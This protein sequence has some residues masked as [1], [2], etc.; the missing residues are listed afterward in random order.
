[1]CIWSRHSKDTMYS[2]RLQ[3]LLRTFQS[4]ILRVGQRPT[5]ML[6]HPTCTP[7]LSTSYPASSE[8][9]L[10]KLYLKSCTSEAVLQRDN[11]CIEACTSS[12]CTKPR[13]PTKT[14][15]KAPFNQPGMT[16]NCALPLQQNWN[17]TTN[18]NLQMPC[19]AH[20]QCCACCASMLPPPS[21]LP[22]TALL[23]LQ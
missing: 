21:S 13:H 3:A 9:V 11:V 1:M 23:L 10:W 15:A 12:K 14:R 8:A 19:G 16:C 4:C 2:L 5:P 17:H 22:K 18:H 6:Q 20:S 7:D